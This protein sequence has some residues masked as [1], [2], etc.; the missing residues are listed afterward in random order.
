[1][2]T[3]EYIKSKY[4]CS[5]AATFPFEIKNLDRE[6]LFDYDWVTA[7]PKCSSQEELE[8]E[9]QA[10]IEG[11]DDFAD[12]RQEI[13]DIMFAHKDGNSSERVWN[14]IEKNYL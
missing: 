13:R 12:K 11:K 9:I 6:L 8:K 2:N 4:S 1:M 3:L 10:Y 7:G 5:N 14:F